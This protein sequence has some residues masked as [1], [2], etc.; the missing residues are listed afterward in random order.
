MMKSKAN[1]EVLFNRER[2]L[3]IVTAQGANGLV[4]YTSIVAEDPKSAS[5]HKVSDSNFEAERNALV[6]LGCNRFC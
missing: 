3:K 6:M 5:V 4:Y 2:G 1:A